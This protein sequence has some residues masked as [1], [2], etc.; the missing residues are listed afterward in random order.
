[1]IAIS[2]NLAD[3][4]LFDLRFTLNDCREYE[5]YFARKFDVADAQSRIKCVMMEMNVAKIKWELSSR[6]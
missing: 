3:Q 6:N 2:V 4:M 5:I 1:M